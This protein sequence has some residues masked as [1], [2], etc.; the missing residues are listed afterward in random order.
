[1]GLRLTLI[2]RKHTPDLKV[3]V[4]IEIKDPSNLAG[5][6]IDLRAN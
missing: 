5:D 3:G 4:T 2:H 1:M 6:I